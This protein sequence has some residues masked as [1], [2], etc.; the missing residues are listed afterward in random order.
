MERA[1][2]AEIFAG[3][4]QANVF[5]DNPNNVGLLLDSLRSGTRFRHFD[6]GA[7]FYN[8]HRFAAAV[9]AFKTL[10]GHERMGF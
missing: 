6:L 5:A 8:R 1:E 9:F 2:P 3:F 10:I 7:Q 4:L